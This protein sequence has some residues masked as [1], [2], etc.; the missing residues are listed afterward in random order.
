MPPQ[1]VAVECGSWTP[2][3]DAF[4]RRQRILDVQYENCC[5]CSSSA[6]SKALKTEQCFFLLL[7]MSE[8]DG[9][10]E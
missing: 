10:E 3:E 8:A 2:V 1:V 4:L 7:V 5:D 9:N 6:D